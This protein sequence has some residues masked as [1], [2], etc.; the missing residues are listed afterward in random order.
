MRQGKSAEEI[1]AREWSPQTNVGAAVLIPEEYVPDLTVRLSLY[2]KLAEVDADGDREAFAAELIDR[3]GPLPPEAA[4][5]LA[6]AGLKALCKR[7][8]IAKLDA[9]PKGA[10]CS[11]RQGGFANPAGLVRLVQRRPLD[12]KLRPDGKLI[13]TGQ[14]ADAGL[15]LKALRAVLEALEEAARAQAA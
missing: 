11:F 4:Q 9:G 2:R 15:R 8:N 1:G 6:V 10:S 5:L 14:W 13:A 3:F 7:L 12:F